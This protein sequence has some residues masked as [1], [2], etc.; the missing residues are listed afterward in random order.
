MSAMLVSSLLSTSTLVLLHV[1]NAGFQLFHVSNAGFQL[2]HVS[3]AGFQLFE[4]INMCTI[5][6][7]QCWFPAVSIFSSSSAHLQLI[8]SS[9]SAYFQLILSSRSTTDFTVVQ[10]DLDQCLGLSQFVFND[11]LLL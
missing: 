6:C 8:F 1:S 7:Q 3:S 4:L 9:S 10:S 11:Q 2:F 5:S